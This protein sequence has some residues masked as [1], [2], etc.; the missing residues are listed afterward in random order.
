MPSTCETFGIG[1][2]VGL[3]ALVVEVLL[4]TRIIIKQDFQPSKTCT[5]GLFHTFKIPLKSLLHTK[6]T[7]AQI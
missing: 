1:P 7:S 6:R 3:L 5:T 4:D 2:L